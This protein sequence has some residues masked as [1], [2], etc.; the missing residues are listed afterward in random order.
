MRRIELEMRPWGSGTLCE[1]ENVL[2]REIQIDIPR[3]M[4]NAARLVGRGNDS[5]A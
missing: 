3:F 1:M 2:I 5:S 4:V